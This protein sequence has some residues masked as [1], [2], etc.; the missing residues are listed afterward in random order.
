MSVLKCDFCGRTQSKSHE[1]WRQLFTR[2]FTKHDDEKMYMMCPSCSER[3]I[4]NNIG[5]VLD[6]EA[7]LDSIRD[8][9]DDKDPRSNCIGLTLRDF[10]Q[11][12]YY[13]QTPD[14][15]FCDMTGLEITEYIKYMT[16]VV[17][18]IRRPDQKNRIRVELDTEAMNKHEDIQT[19]PNEAYVDTEAR[20]RR[21]EKKSR[22]G[23]RH[24]SDANAGE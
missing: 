17:K 3:I 11:T 24:G 12:E 22:F 16:A 6:P 10:L 7:E 8:L 21:Y 20:D 9:F 23:I 19:E 1:G 14:I 18:M 4:E 5:T 13:L 2:S 15:Y